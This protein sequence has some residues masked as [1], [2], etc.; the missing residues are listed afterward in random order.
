M[1]SHPSSLRACALWLLSTVGFLHAADPSSS[2][3]ASAPAA[4][5]L[6]TPWSSMDFDGVHAPCLPGEPLT[7]RL[8]SETTT[9]TITVDGQPHTALISLGTFLP[10]IWHEPWAH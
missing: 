10:G 6:A 7:L 4:N 5:R 1:V 9:L 3:V 2:P 8:T